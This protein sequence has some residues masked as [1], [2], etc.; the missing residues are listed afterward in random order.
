MVCMQMELYHGPDAL[1]EDVSHVACDLGLC[2]VFRVF[3]LTYEFFSQGRG[4]PVHASH[5]SHA[6]GCFSTYAFVASEPA[7]VGV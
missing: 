1:R 6:R 5:V 3:L 2:I 4:I 7:W